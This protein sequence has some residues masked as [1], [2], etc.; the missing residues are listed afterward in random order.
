MSTSSAPQQNQS[1]FD[2]IRVFLEM[3]KFS[4]TLFA[5]P[6][7]FTG[8]VLAAGGLPTPAQCGWILAA[9]VG[10]RTAAMGLNRVIDA[11]ID[12]R[13]P[14]TSSR[15]IPA[16]LLGKGTVVVFIVASLALLLFAAAQL[17]PLCL[18]LAPVAVFFLV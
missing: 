10:A 1:I 4:H 6:F 3:I 2:R 9:M 17:N 15:A 12:A 13:N 11:E 14:R 18:K 8:A 7:A 5:L 16:G